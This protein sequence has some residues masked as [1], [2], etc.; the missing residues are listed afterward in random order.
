MANWFDGEHDGM[1]FGLW[2]ACQCTGNI[3]GAAYGTY[4][5]IHNLDIQWNYWLPA[6][7]AALMGIILFLTVPTYPK[8]MKPNTDQDKKSN[9]N[10]GGVQ[11]VDEEDD[12]IQEIKKNGNEGVGLIA[13]LR[14]PNVI[15][16]GLIFA[17]IKG[18]NYT[19]FFWLPDFLENG[20]G[21]FSDHQG[22]TFQIYY[23]VGQIVG[24]LFC[25]WVSDRFSKRSPTLFVFLLLSV[26]PIFMLRIP[27]SSA[28]YISIVCTVTGFMMGGPSNLI[29]S[30]MAAEV[31]KMQAVKGNPA[32]LATLSGIVDGMGGIG[33][34]ICVYIA[35]YIPTSTVFVM[36]SILI[37]LSAILLLPLTIK[38]VKYMLRQRNEQRVNDNEKSL[39]PA[40]YK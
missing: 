34:A 31:G 8:G 25:G 22:D 5:D 39:M 9:V 32:S 13:A 38:D 18:V 36:L 1:I 37:F 17:C 6:V 33:A 12:R 7:Q 21:H 29:S 14:L 30:V 3:I 2:T 10:N 40:E 23:N 4:V 27:T 28:T 19:L 26:T 35:T 15:M 20:S 16:Y 24:S 11:Y